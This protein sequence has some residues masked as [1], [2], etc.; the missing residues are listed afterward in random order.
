[1]H[2][3]ADA[4]DKQPRALSL[5]KEHDPTSYEERQRIQAAG[6]KVEEGRVQGILQV[7]RS[8]GDGRFK[9]VG[10]INTPYVVKATLSEDTPFCIIACD[11]LWEQF[12]AQDAVA[13]IH[14]HVGK[15]LAATGDV[16]EIEQLL[17][18]ASV[19]LV[20]EAVKR[21]SQDNVTVLLVH[22][23]QPSAFN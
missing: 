18:Q 5:S 14:A 3:D 12:S 22:F 13:L 2:K 11:G 16:T 17:S 9:G 19:A 8:I 23:H 20:N 21:G 6:G 15:Q 4:A 7:S 1:M 10:V